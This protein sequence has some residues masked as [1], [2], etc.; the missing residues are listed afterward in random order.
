MAGKD[1]TT[2]IEILENQ[3]ANLVARLDVQDV[4]VKGI[5]EG[6]KKWSDICEGHTTK[7]TVLEQN[8]FLVDLK[9]LKETISTIEKDIVAIRKDV[10]S[11]GKW[12]DDLKKE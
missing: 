11:L 3:A 5:T 4:L 2:R 10:E 7:I 6:L 12:K 8:L 9:V 1:N